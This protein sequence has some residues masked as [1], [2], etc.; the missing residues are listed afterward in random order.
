MKKVTMLLILMLTFTAAHAAV[1]TLRADFR[2]RPPEM[3]V[4][5]NQFSGPLKEIIEQ[6][7][8]KTGYKIKWRKAPFI[9]SLKG[10]KEGSVDILPRTVR[11]EA[12]EKF[13]AFLGPIG[14]QNK[15]IIFLV[16]KGNEDLI[17]HYEDL[18]GLKIAVKRGTA[19]FK[20]FNE[21][22]GLEKQVHMDD[23][24][25]VRMFKRGRFDTM[26][27]LDRES[28]EDAL[29]K[30]KISDYAYA[31][32]KYIQKNGNYYGMPKKY[33]GSRM[34]SLLNKSLLNMVT[35]GEITHIYQQYG[36]KP[37]VQNKENEQ[38]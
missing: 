31:N 10:V 6:A 8:D 18:Y 38:P 23:T 35:S 12:R 17:N 7:A 26:V 22:N 21:D 27:V 32:Y 25:M 16:K 1:K 24:N 15:D 33:A 2:H 5:G 20:R 14:Y 11:N 13:I 3:V 9:R 28:L 36:I 4:S 30:H 19:Y 34:F 29:R 37:P